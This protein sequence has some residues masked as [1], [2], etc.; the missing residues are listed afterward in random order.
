LL[1]IDAARLKDAKVFCIARFGIFVLATTSPFFARGSQT[2][3]F[4]SKEE[5]K[6]KITEVENDTD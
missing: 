3:G 5:P 4:Q 6:L 2:Q 1:R